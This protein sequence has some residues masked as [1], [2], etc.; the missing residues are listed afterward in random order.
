MLQSP[1]PYSPIVRAISYVNKVL[2]SHFGPNYLTRGRPYCEF[3]S[4]AMAVERQLFL[5]NIPGEWGMDRVADEI[6]AYGV[7]PLSI[8]LRQRRS[9]E[10][11][12][13]ILTFASQQLQALAL[14]RRIIWSTGRVALLMP[15]LGKQQDSATQTSN[16][17]AILKSG[18]V[19]NLLGDIVSNRIGQISG[20]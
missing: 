15:S 9:G 19:G 17:W 4:A 14:S 3:R 10:D 1:V 13:G 2:R 20:G 8:N 18:R 6:G 5:G 16:A 12:Y 11:S 7:Y